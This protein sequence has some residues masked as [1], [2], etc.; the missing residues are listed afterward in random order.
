M[1]PTIVTLA[2]ALVLTGGIWLR[3]Q[4]SEPAPTETASASGETKGARCEAMCA[5]KHTSQNPAD[6]L[7][8]NQKLNLSDKQRVRLRAIEDKATN[9]AKALLSAEQQDK[10]KELSRS[11]SMMQCMYLMK[12]AVQTDAKIGDDMSVG[13]SHMEEKAEAPSSSH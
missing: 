10:L 5:M 4:Q 11:Q 6:L 8:W 3:A 13:C 2:A 9:E 1:K 7:A 12:H